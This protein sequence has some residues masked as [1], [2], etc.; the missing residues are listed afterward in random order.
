MKTMITKEITIENVFASF[1]ADKEVRAGADEVVFTFTNESGKSLAEV[2]ASM[3]NARA[4]YEGVKTR[5]RAH[6]RP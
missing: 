2:A 6:Q 1:L 4:E 3:L 5:F